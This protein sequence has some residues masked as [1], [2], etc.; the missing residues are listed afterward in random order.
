MKELNNNELLNV[1]GGAVNS[2]LIST[3]VKG[4]TVFFEIGRSLGS[5]FRRL[6]SSRTCKI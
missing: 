4:S 6:I 2:S 1:E 5:S 3:L